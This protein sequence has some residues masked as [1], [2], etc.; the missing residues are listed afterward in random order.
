MATR[1]R[2][3]FGLGGV[4]YLLLGA[5]L[6]PAS[7]SGQEA[8][9]PLQLSFSDP[10]ARSMG[11]GGAFVGLADDATAAIA[12]PAGLT[13]LLKPEISLEA[14][15]W[16]HSIPFTEGGRLE[17][18]PSGFGLDTTVGLRRPTSDYDVT[19]I[20]FLSFAYPRGN[21]SFALYRHQLAEL[22][23]SGET[24]GLF[25]G[26]TDCCQ[27]R[28]VDQRFSSDLK[29]V[30]WGLS[31][32]YRLSDRL[33]IGLGLVYNNGT[34]RTSSQQFLVDDDTLESIFG[35]NSYLPERLVAEQNSQSGDT[36]WTLSAGLLWR[37]IANWSIGGVY[38]QGPEIETGIETLVGQAI[39]FG[40]PP[41]TAVFQAFDYPI[42]FPDSWGLGVAY[43]AP[44]GSLAVSFQWDHVSYS[45]I[46]RSLRLD[47]QT[48]DDTDSLHLGA[49]YV[50][51]DWTPIVALRLGTWLEPDHQ[52]RATVDELYMRA[53]LPPGDDV[54]HYSAGVGIAMRRF[55]L[56]F[57]VDVAD[58][59]DTYALSAIYNF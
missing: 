14:R 42:E 48:V 35:R 24:Q 49:E 36:D 27:V 46:T 12:N 33:D 21:W 1:S 19:G 55:Q 3:R 8:I 54:M 30:S 28:E 50:F 6:L 17:N 58:R 40:V 20:S 44:G 15:H 26:G 38:R 11:F 23:F 10:G 45:N 13:Q 56:D 39:D 32:A 22:E 9:V 18:L 37:P 29:M 7:G 53:L 31:V 34:V 41:G 5:L 47:D 4:V 43:R 2:H 25:Y 16:R 59:L 52:I 51:L 57:A